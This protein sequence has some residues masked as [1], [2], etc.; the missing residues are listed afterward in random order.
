MVEHIV[1]NYGVVSSILTRGTYYVHPSFAAVVQL[2]EHLVANEKVTGSTPVRR[3]SITKALF[4]IDKNIFSDMI[5]SIP[6]EG[7][8]K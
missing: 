3:S 4:A 1:E 8:L 7:I 5:I 2:V 6:F